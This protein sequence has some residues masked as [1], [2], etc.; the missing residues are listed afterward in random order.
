[1]SATDVQALLG[2][3]SQWAGTRG[4][5]SGTYSYGPDSEH[6]AD[7][8]LPD[9][10]GPH[11]VAVLL[12]GGFWRARFTRAIMAALATDLSDRGWAVWNLEYR[13]VGS[14]GGAATT[15]ADVRRA[16][17]FLA[18]LEQPLDVHRLLVIG[19]SA[20]GQLALCAASA[21]GV[22]RIVSLAGV[23]DLVSAA[24]QGI[25]DNAAVQ[26]IGATPA[27]RPDEYA[28][29]DPLQ[30][31]PTG[32]DVLLVHGDADDRVPLQL[33]RDYATAARAAGDS[34][35]LLELPGVDHFA[36]IDPRSDAWSTIAD[37]LPPART[38]TDVALR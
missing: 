30:R 8:W 10:A 5:A 22:A 4:G 34:C 32:V 25:G 13:R 38:M 17:E 29:A 23:C 15:P 9:G 14:G 7:L 21:P 11:P 33:S 18:D 12:H 31:L 19:H 28:L 1:M 2:E 6:Q 36:V 3:L 20:G 27:Q 37:R 16:I 35:E 26:F 24:D